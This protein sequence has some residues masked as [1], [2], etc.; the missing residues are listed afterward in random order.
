MDIFTRVVMVIVGGMFAISA[1]HKDFGLSGPFSRGPAT[2]KATLVGRACFF[3]VGAISVFSG[4][5]GI[6]EFWTFSK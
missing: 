6:T 2:H 1:F 5:T 4:L 3:L